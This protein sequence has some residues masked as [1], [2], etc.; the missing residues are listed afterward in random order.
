MTMALSY[1]QRKVLE[2][3]ALAWQLDCGV[4][5]DDEAAGYRSAE[6]LRPDYWYNDFDF[7][8]LVRAGLLEIYNA[9]SPESEEYFRITSI[10]LQLLSGR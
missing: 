10:G 4:E 1:D 9:I 7:E 5:E 8:P 6:W 2:E 3:A